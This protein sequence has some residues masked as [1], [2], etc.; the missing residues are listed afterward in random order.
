[1]ASLRRLSSSASGACASA[2][3]CPL[4]VDARHGAPVACLP[5]ARTTLRPPP[6]PR[7]WPW[8]NAPDMN[9][10]FPTSFKIASQQGLEP[11]NGQPT[12]SN[13]K[14]TL[15]CPFASVVWLATSARYGEVL[16]L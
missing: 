7:L 13:W 1:M 9:S 14:Q 6:P 15:S 5:F 4:V 10:I 16:Q 2:L 11:P 8:G 12:V 3:L